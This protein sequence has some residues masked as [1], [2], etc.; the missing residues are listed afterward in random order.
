MF[1]EVKLTVDGATQQFWWVAPVPVVGTPSLTIRHP[2]A[3][4][5]TPTFS[6]VHASVSISAISSDRRTL[7][8]TATVT[9]A[10][11]AQGS[12]FGGAFLVTPRDGYFDC[13]VRRVAGTSIILAEPVLR[14]QR[15]ALKDIWML[16]PCDWPGWNPCR[17][18]LIRFLHMQCIWP[19]SWN[20]RSVR[21][22]LRR[23]WIGMCRFGQNSRWP[24][25][26][27]ICAGE[28]FGM[29]WR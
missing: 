5:T 16:R 9:N 24:V 22:R 26:R 21:L 15:F 19:D 25:M 20:A 17:G 7:T 18:G 12:R 8:A 1:N 6:R 10:A 14:G 3:G 27:S 2:T 29:R 4:S 11:G 23:R 13:T 28:A